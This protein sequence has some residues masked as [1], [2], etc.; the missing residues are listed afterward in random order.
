[1]ISA[2]VA[3]AVDSNGVAEEEGARRRG[4]VVQDCFVGFLRC[5]VGIPS[6]ES[7]LLEQADVT[8]G[9]ELT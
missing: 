6:D 1:M 9:V 4:V 2:W 5:P 3:S 8:I 7:A